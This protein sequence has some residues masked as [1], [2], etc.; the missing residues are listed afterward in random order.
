[1]VGTIT[2][3]AAAT[4]PPSTPTALPGPTLITAVDLDGNNSPI[5]GE[6]ADKA[7]DGT[8]HGSYT[9]L[10]GAN[11]G[12]EFTYD[13]DKGDTRIKVTATKSGQ[14]AVVR[15]RCVAPSPALGR[16]SGADHEAQLMRNQQV[17]ANKSR[18]VSSDDVRA[19][20][21]DVGLSFNMTALMA[22]YQR[23]LNER[24]V[25]VLLESS[26]PDGPSRIG[27]PDAFLE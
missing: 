14:D 20:K 5:S 22:R 26:F 4:T 23:E 18:D 1:V 21:E 25:S 8:L 7:F 27:I 2:N 10:G 13:A 11:S 16:P 6:G 19:V 15:G 12:I 17:K 24:G 3:D 9:N